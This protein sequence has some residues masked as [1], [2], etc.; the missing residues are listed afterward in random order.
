MKKLAITNFSKEPLLSAVM[1]VVLATALD[2][3]NGAFK[4][5]TFSI[6]KLLVM[7]I[8]NLFIGFI[9]YIGW[10]TLRQKYQKQYYLWYW[11]L[12][13]LFVAIHLLM[14]WSLFQVLAM[15]KI[16]IK[17]LAVVF[18]IIVAIALIYQCF[19]LNKIFASNA[20]L[21]VIYLLTF[22]AILMLGLENFAGGNIKYITLNLVD[23]KVI[24]WSFDG[25]LLVILFGFVRKFAKEGGAQH[26][27]TTIDI[28]LAIIWGIVAFD[29]WLVW[30]LL[31][32]LDH[33]SIISVL[34][35][36]TVFVVKLV[37]IGHYL[38]NLRSP[39]KPIYAM[40]LLVASSFFTQVVTNAVYYLGIFSI[41]IWLTGLSSMQADAAGW[42]LIYWVVIM[43]IIKSIIYMIASLVIMLLLVG[44]FFPRKTS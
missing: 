38:N 3:Y 19:A 40:W 24:K 39:I 4:Y 31:N 17:A 34:I 20:K 6:N 8:S 33:R 13:V 32:T 42:Y 37:V 25:L 30:Q 27:V 21:T 12:P 44:V 1:T 26:E 5:A 23:L 28:K 14:P 11:L 43:A 36:L 35:S 2:I 16:N 15:L 7:V 22:I 10:L 9:V 29:G 41:Y 18:S